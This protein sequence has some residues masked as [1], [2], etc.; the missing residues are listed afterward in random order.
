MFFTQL[1]PP[2]VEL[3]CRRSLVQF[4][5]VNT[6]APAHESALVYTLMVGVGAWQ[7]LSVGLV[8]AGAFMPRHEEKLRVGNV[9]LVPVL[10]PGS[11]GL[12]A[13]GAL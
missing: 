2:D 5:P 12:V 9:T 11:V 3:P 4:I 7:I 8:A 10:A 6:P 13:A 1:R